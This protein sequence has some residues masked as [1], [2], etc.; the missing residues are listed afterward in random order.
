MF[1]DA[2]PMRGILMMWNESRTK[3]ARI[4]DSAGSTDS[5]TAISSARRTGAY[6]M[7][8]FRCFRAE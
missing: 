4:G 6:Y 3:R 8:G 1:Q 2:T 7:A 5:F